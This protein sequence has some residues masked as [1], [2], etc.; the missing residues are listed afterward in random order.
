MS[1]SNCNLAS[2][3]RL[4]SSIGHF[5][6]PVAQV[7]PAD[8]TCNINGRDSCRLC[9]H[10]QEV[11]DRVI[12]TIHAGRVGRQNRPGLANVK[13]RSS[14]SFLEVAMSSATRSYQYESRR[15]APKEIATNSAPPAA[16]VPET[17]LDSEE[18]AA[19]MKIHPKTPPKLDRRSAVRVIHVGNRAEMRGIEAAAMSI[20]GGTVMIPEPFVSAQEA[21]KFVGISRRFLTELARRGIAG[22]YPIGTGELRKTWV[23]RLSE[24]AAAIDCNS[25]RSSPRPPESDRAYH[26][27]IRRSLL[28]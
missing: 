5:Q 28:K 2:N 17:L 19:V 1:K 21:A 24:L 14:F 22:A 12:T 7:V 18:A 16:S 13:C 8:R 26:P 20:V 27:I 10:R 25:D 9:R 15:P 3:H 23:F 6:V 4:Y 11:L